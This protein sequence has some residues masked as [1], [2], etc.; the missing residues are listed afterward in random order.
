M[1]PE[2]NVKYLAMIIDNNLSWDDHINN[3]K[4]KLS[5]SNGILAKLRSYVPK[6]TLTS[7]Y[8]VIFHSQ[9]LYGSLLWSLTTAKFF[10]CIKVL[11]KKNV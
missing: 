11:Q 9:L 2:T 3:L 8:Y 10:Y 4:N 7:V 6:K 1:I 5:R